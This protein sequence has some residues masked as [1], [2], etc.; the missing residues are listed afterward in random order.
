MRSAPL[1]A[2]VLAFTALD[3]ADGREPSARPVTIPVVWQAPVG[4]FQPRAGDIPEGIPLFPSREE[5]DRRDRAIDEK[6]QI[7]RGC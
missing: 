6:L 7:C 2:C 3:R 4:H 1:F 5:Q